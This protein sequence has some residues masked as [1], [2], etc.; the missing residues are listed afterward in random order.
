MLFSAFHV[1][2][3]GFEPNPIRVSL[4]HNK[5]LSVNST[6]KALSLE[7]NYKHV[8]GKIT[9]RKRK[10]LASED[11]D[12]RDATVVVCTKEDNTSKCILAQFIESLEHS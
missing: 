4:T 8:A 10:I 11:P 5:I 12:A 7:R 3:I 2:G 9:H 1:R 6:N